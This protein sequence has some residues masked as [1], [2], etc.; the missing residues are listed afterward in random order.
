MEA[1]GG[2]LCGTS[3]GHSVT[4]GEKSNVYRTVGSVC[5]SSKVYVSEKNKFSSAKI[6]Y[7][8]LIIIVERY[9]VTGIQPRQ[10][11]PSKSPNKLLFL[12]LFLSFW[13][14]FL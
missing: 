8:K 9:R 12:A 11:W 3:Q 13:P 1:L 10:W 4:K 2:S 7:S 5:G 14:W 6:H